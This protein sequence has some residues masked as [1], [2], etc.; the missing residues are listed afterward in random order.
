MLA[1][2]L[3]SLLHRAYHLQED[4]GSGLPA[5]SV[6]ADFGETQFENAIVEDCLFFYL[7][8]NNS[9]KKVNIIDKVND[10]CLIRG[11]QKL[12]PNSHPNS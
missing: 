5:D 12:C 9:N 2:K 1:E 3:E 8:K 4:F 10:C 7:I 11:S 6:L